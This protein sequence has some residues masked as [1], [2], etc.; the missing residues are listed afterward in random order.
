MTRRVGHRFNPSQP[1]HRISPRSSPTPPPG[2]I[3]SHTP[4]G[5]GGSSFAHVP[6]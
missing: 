1:Q 3:L 4:L 5:I 6:Q 2:A